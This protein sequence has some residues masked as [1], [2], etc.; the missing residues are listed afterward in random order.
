M[1]KD[2]HGDFRGGLEEAI[3]TSISVALPEGEMP[4]G[5]ERFL[6]AGLRTEQV[7][8]PPLRWV[9]L[10]SGCG[11]MSL[12]VWEAAYADK[13]RAEVALSVDFAEAAVSVFRDNFKDADAR[14]DDIT[15]LLSGCES[16]KIAAKEQ[17]LRETVGPVDLLIG[18]PPCQ[19]H[20]DLNNFSRR[21]DP[22]NRL[23][24]Y[25]ARAA[26]VFEPKAVIIENVRGVPHDRTGVLAYTSSYLEQLG[27]HLSDGLI[28]VSDFGVAQK[29]IRHVLL[30]TKKPVPDLDRL[31]APYA[32]GSRS[33]RWAIGD[34]MDA[35]SESLLDQTS[36]P[37]KDNVRR[38]SYLFE[39][40]LFDLPDSERPPCHRDKAHTYRSVYGRMRW[41]DLAQTVTSGFYSMCMGR[42][43][44]PERI[45]TLTAHEAARLQFI[46]DSFSFKSVSTRTALAEMIGNAVP[47]KLTYVLVRA[48]LKQGAL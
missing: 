39:N 18:G 47:P 13:R 12:G 37:S 1:L 24:P 43:V 9:D 6:K 15:E 22:R 32:L 7:D 10:F 11:A 5:D 34:L 26:E 21:N 48:L 35:D 25:M 14:C 27:Y 41:E 3:E 2:I 30:A 33:I 38:M 46:P 8:G 40:G 4:L 36:R 42:Y 16:G 45:S 29:R 44:H 17:T 28:D 20:S 19:G 23:Y 31:L